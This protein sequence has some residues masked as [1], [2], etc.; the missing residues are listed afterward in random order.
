MTDRMTT[1]EMNLKHAEPI[2]YHKYSINRNM[3]EFVYRSKM[4][5]LKQRAQNIDYNIC[6]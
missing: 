2:S 6:I 4:R 1:G 5:M 3:P